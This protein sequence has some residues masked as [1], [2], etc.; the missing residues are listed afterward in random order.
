MSAWI[1]VIGERDALRW[2]LERERMAFRSHVHTDALAEG[3]DVV[4]YATRGCWHNP[5][6]DR[7]QIVA[8]GTLA[9]PVAAGPITV[10][11]ERMARSCP[12]ALTAILP[13]RN[14]VPFERL[15][16]R[17]RMTNGKTHWGLVMRRTIVP[18]C[19]ADHRTIVAAV[20]RRERETQTSG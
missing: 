5:T 11:G 4:I 20:V 6:R 1:F 15:V 18:L 9:G 3:D 2:V 13:D 17:L 16:D 8:I 12:L 7:S 10:A 14:G 19:A